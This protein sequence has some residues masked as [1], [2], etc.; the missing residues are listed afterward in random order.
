MSDRQVRRRSELDQIRQKE[1]QVLERLTEQW[2]GSTPFLSEE[3][4]HRIMRMEEI[5]V[6]LRRFGK[7]VAIGRRMSSSELFCKVN[8]TSRGWLWTRTALIREQRREADEA[9]FD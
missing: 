7:L 1:A 4:W 3:V 9:M 2:F 6:E 8:L 5:P